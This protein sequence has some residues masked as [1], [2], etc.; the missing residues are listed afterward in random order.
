MKIVQTMLTA[1][2]RRFFSLELLNN[3]FWAFGGRFSALAGQFIAGIFAARVLGPDEFGTLNYVISLVTIFSVLAAFGLDFIEIRELAGKER[4]KDIDLPTLLILRLCLAGFTLLLLV[5]CIFLFQ[6]T[7]ANAVY[8]LV[9]SV[10]FIF[11]AFNPIR[12]YFTAI[13]QNKLIV[14]SELIR[15]IIGTVLKLLLIFAHAPLVFIIAA[16]AFDYVLL[17]LGYWR[18]YRI[19]VGHLKFCF[20]RSRALFYLREAFPLLLSSAVIIVYQKIDQVIIHSLMNDSA[21]GQFAVA[22]KIVEIVTI[23]PVVVSQT[24]MP[25]LVKSREK[26]PARYLQ[27]QQRMMDLTVWTSVLIAFMVC[28]CAPFLIPLFFGNQYNAGIGA[29]QIMAWKVPAMALSAVSGHL[30]IIAGLQKYAIWRN[31]FGCVLC[32]ALNYM[33]IPRYG[34]NGSAVASLVTMFFSGFFSHVLIPPYFGIL[35]IQIRAILFGWKDLWIWG[36][37]VFLTRKV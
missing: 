25:V 21:V 7:A 8:V 24:I 16:Y 26:D 11:Q 5:G 17:G 34:I 22:G 37:H 10:M 35:K 32:V 13:L 27:Q 6:L 30:I 15:N 36:Y 4:K 2:K 28:F 19:Y 23:I 14:L 18:V 1:C 9:Y 12:N 33:L 3:V 29:L 20:N 31:I